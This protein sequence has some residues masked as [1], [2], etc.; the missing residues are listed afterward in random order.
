[1]VNSTENEMI[2]KIY[3]S[4]EEAKE[5]SK[6]NMHFGSHGETH[7]NFRLLDFNDQLSEVQFFFQ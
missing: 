2:N 4:V 7:R 1:M 3:L 5:M 6:N